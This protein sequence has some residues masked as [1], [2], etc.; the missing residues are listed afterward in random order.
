MEQSKLAYKFT[1]VEKITEDLI[2]WIREWFEQNGKGCN[3]VIGISGGKDSTISA[4][5][6][7]KALGKDRVIGIR[8]PNG[9]QYDIDD[10]VRVCEYLGIKSYE[11]NIQ[12]IE[13][14]IYNSVPDSAQV[15]L[16]SQSRINLPARIRMTVLYFYS[17]SLNG[18][19]VNNCNLS[20]NWVGYSTR[21]GDAAGD[22][23]PLQNLTVTEIKQIG[24]YLGLPADLVDKDPSD[25]LC[26]ST[27]EDAFGFSY[28][29]L[30]LYIRLGIAPE[31]D[32]K[33][34]IDYLNRVNQF[35]LK[36][37][38]KFIPEAIGISLKEE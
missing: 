36:L 23:A 18:R 3:A 16:S 34:R 20:E 38:P 27:D 24:H 7:V 32:K 31:Q 1:N 37:I 35:K 33:E 15:P 11:H 6:C 17:Q 12:E 21:Y 8:M 5:L 25:G 19:V 4:A 22:F 9:K 29:E 14:A 26:G 2:Q 13:V 10:A 30:D 28:N